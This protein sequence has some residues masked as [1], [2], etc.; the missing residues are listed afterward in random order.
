MTAQMR[1]TGLPVHR[2]PVRAD[3]IDYNGHLNVAYYGLIFDH[4]TDL[5]LDSV[6]LGPRYVAAGDGSLFVVEAHTLYQQELRL[7]DMAVVESRLLGV[8]DKRVHLFHRMFD[9][10]AD[11]QAATTELMLLHVDL[12]T[13]RSGVMPALA[14]TRLADLLRDQPHHPVPEEAGRRIALPPP[15]T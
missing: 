4:A 11:F 9:G 7:G 15:K 14:R 3:W 13:R 8:D 5:V 1:E 6:G 2:E 12:T 10:E